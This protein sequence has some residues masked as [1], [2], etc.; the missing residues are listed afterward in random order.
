MKGNV[1]TLFLPSKLPAMNDPLI[2]ADA[3]SIKVTFRF[4]ILTLTL[5]MGYLSLIL[6]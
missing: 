4:V 6:L 5:L 3:V 2:S 1:F